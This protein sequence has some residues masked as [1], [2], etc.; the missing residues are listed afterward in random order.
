V[1]L[2]TIFPPMPTPFTGGDIDIASIRHNVR[3]WMAAGLGG[4]VALGTNGEAPLL[5]DEEGDLV[6]AAVRQEVPPDRTLVVGIGRESTK[7]T[8]AAATRAASLGADAVLARTPSM[9]RNHVTPAALIAH[10]RAVADASPVPLLLYNFP[11]NTGVNLTPDLVSRVAEHPNVAGMKETSTDGAQ[12]AELSAAVPE[13]FTVMAGSA[14][15]LFAALC[16]GAKGGIVAIA[17]VM[18]EACLEL[19]ALVRAGRLSE[20]LALQ[21]RL[22]PIARAVTSGFGIP[23][24]KTAMSLTGYQGGEPR[25]PLAPLADDAVEKIRV[26]LN[27]VRA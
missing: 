27:A 17:C 4:V 14:P 21:Q 1:D 5:D 16:A 22:S 10:Y 19:L 12:F 9:Y 2:R 3:R 11:A 20:A 23:G 13:R 7:A 15:G 25:A 6:V 8:I 18:P 26:L 24:L